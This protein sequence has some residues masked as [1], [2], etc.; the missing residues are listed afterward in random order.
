MNRTDIERKFA[1]FG[2]II[3]AS[4]ADYDRERT[5]YFYLREAISW[6]HFALAHPGLKDT[7][8]KLAR[9]YFRS[10]KNKVATRRYL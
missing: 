5:A 7:A 9:S 2:S 1:L 4:T 3:P 10:Y 6:R 8:L